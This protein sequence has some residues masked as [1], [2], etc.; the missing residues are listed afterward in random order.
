[1]HQGNYDAETG[2]VTYG[3]YYSQQNAKTGE[4]Y[5][6]GES[7]EVETLLTSDD[8]TVAP[9]A[10]EHIAS[11]GPRIYLGA[12]AA[13]MTKV[14]SGIMGFTADHLPLVGRLE[15][16]V[17]GRSG[18]GEWIAAGY[19]GHG[20]DKCWLTGQAIAKMALGE[21]VSSWFPESFRITE[22]RLKAS[23]LE[24]VAAGIADTF[25][26]HAAKL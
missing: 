19:S 16:V 14:W 20:M 8:S 1:M 9:S 2:R 7:Q 17:T 21:D 22:E 18:S 25:I 26:P 3:L 23:T 15:N 10:S 4:I 6:G 11:I 24:S 12:D 5:I 13:K